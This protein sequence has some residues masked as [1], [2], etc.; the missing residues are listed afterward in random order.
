MARVFFTPNLS[1]H[2]GNLNGVSPGRTVR[3]VLD[4][5]FAGHA[6]AKSYVL[7]DQGALRHHMNIMVAGS[8]LRD[9]TGLG[10]PVADDAEIFVLQALSG[11]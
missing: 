2:I 4:A 3:E 8:P 10:D 7:D 6:F 1:R 11:G 5:H 9:R